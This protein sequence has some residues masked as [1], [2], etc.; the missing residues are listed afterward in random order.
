MLDS[1]QTNAGRYRINYFQQST[2]TQIGHHHG[3]KRSWWPEHLGGPVEGVTLNLQ[4]HPSARVHTSRA[5]H[6]LWSVTKT[7]SNLFTP[8]Q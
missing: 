2:E 5:L 8:A 7:T 3:L 6:R 4:P 1:R